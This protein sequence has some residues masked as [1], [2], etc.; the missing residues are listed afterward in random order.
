LVLLKEKYIKDFG[1]V[2][3]KKNILIEGCNRWL[4]KTSLWG[5]PLL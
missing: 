5:D 4:G 1:E 3:A 2:G